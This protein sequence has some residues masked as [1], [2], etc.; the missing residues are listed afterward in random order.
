MIDVG[1]ERTS[2]LLCCAAHE[3]VVGRWRARRVHRLCTLT[4]L[5]WCVVLRV[6]LV[7]VALAAISTAAVAAE[8]ASNVAAAVHTAT[9]ASATSTVIVTASA[10]VAATHRRHAE[11]FRVEFALRSPVCTL[12]SSG[13][14]NISII[15][16]AVTD[17]KTNKK[18]ADI[19]FFF[20]FALLKDCLIF[21][22]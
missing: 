18:G 3:T 22:V 7:A 10:V 2:L 19:V 8:V 21:L 16:Y 17:F 4:C 5:C 15:N 9:A 11:S 6:L 12:R 20:F 13:T 1:G 14:S